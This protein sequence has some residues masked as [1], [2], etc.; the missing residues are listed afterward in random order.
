MNESQWTRAICD[1]AKMLNTKVTAFVGS[2]M[3]EDGIPDRYWCHTYW[4][5]WLEFKGPKTKLRP[6]QRIFIREHSER[7]PGSAYV[8][9]QPDRIENHLGE[10][11]AYF[12]GTA[13]GLLLVLNELHRTISSR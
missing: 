11:V 1:D 4:C 13:Q 9:R 6:K 12:D 2:M 8:I 10:L 5:G 7:Q 3:Q